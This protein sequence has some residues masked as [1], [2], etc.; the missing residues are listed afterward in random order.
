MVGQEQVHRHLDA[1]LKNFQPTDGG[2]A[3]F[4]ALTSTWGGGKTRTGDELV[5]QVTGESAGWID[6]AG[7]TLPSLMKPDFGDGLV[8]IMVSY[9][10][11]IRQVEDADRRLPFT[12]WIPR[13]TLAALLCLRDHGTP[14]SRAVMEH[15]DSFKPV[16]ARAI[17]DL[18]KLKDLTNEKSVVD[19]ILKVLNEQGLNRVLVIVEEVEDPSEIRNKPQ[20]RVLGD[21]QYQEIKDVYLDVIPEV[22][23][24]DIE[25]QRFPSLGFLLL[26]SPA[27]YSTIEKIPSQARRYYPVPIGRN[28]VADLCG[29]L[30]F[31]RNT[32]ST[33][34]EYGERLIRAAYLAVDRNMGW[35]NVVMHSVHRRFIE[36]DQDPVSLL[37]Q[38]SVT[39]PRGKEV[40]VENGLAR[41]PGSETNS[42]AQSLLFGQTPVLIES[43]DATIRTSLQQMHVLDAAG[44]CAFT[45]LCPLRA[46]LSELLQT[47]QHEAGVQVVSGGGAQVHAG[48]MRVD[49][50]RLLEDLTAYERDDAGRPVLP[51]NREQ[52]VLHVT[53][54][55]GISQTGA[56]ALYLYPVFQ[57]HL[58]EAP[59]HFGP[60]FAALR[61]IDR[62]LQREDIQFRL[63]DDEDTERK[64]NENQ[65]G[66]SAKDRLR[67]LAQGFLNTIDEP[68]PVQEHSSDEAV[69]V[70]A[71][72][73]ER[74]DSLLLAQDSKVWVVVGS[75]GTNVRDI[76][77]SLSATGQPVRPVLLLLSTDDPSQREIVDQFLANRPAIKD[78]VFLFPLAEIDERLLFLKS[79]NYG[80]NSLTNLSRSLLYRLTE[81][82]KEFLSTRF[83]ELVEDG[84]VARPLFR[85]NNWKPYAEE[86]AE[87]WLF[88]AS[89]SAHDLTQARTLLGEQFVANALE[90]L[91]SNK[92]TNKKSTTELVDH[93]SE[94]P[95]PLWSPALARI[96][97]LLKD[98]PRSI[99]FLTSRF[100][101]SGSKPREVVDQLLLWLKSLGLVKHSTQDDT[102][103][104]LK[105]GDIENAAQTAQS[106][107]DNDLKQLLIDVGR[108][109]GIQQKLNADGA[110]MKARLQLL[111]KPDRLDQ[112]QLLGQELSESGDDDLDVARRQTAFSALAVYL[113]FQ[114]RQMATDQPAKG[115]ALAQRAD[116]LEEHLRTRDIPFRDRADGLG[117]FVKRIEKQVDQLH[118]QISAAKGQYLQRLT[119]AHLPSAVFEIPAE[120]LL[121][122]T[123]RDQ[124][125]GQTTKGVM[126][127]ETLIHHLIQGHLRSAERC[128]EEAERRLALL[129]AECDQLIHQ[130]TQFVGEVSELKNECDRYNGECQDLT[131]K[132]SDP[133]F[134]KNHLH[135]LLQQLTPLLNGANDSLTGLQDMVSGD[136]SE[137][138]RSR[139]QGGPPFDQSGEPIL[140]KQAR[141]LIRD[142]HVGAEVSTVRL[143][144]RLEPL[145]NQ[146]SVY[147]SELMAEQGTPSDPGLGLLR[148]AMNRIDANSSLHA[149]QRLE[150]ATTLR[151]LVEEAYRL[152]EEWR[153]AGPLKLGDDDLF[154]FFLKVISD[155]ELGTKGIPPSTDWEK[156]GKLKDQN[157]VTLK[158]KD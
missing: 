98:G 77:Q 82:I 79:E 5:A 50:A 155:T 18:P 124:P 143:R 40:F 108:Y 13:V 137:V 145:A 141:N 72:T 92:P 47:A 100:F 4:C 96:V 60:S 78:R 144:E 69:V 14:Q 6:R 89:D 102:Y 58:A 123:K 105:R 8:P 7:T 150:A 149:Q 66:L 138:I 43:L 70:L 157:L 46:G 88:L 39:D 11:V 16:A 97:E 115:A 51:R 52:F 53:T 63:L 135:H 151:A 17:R 45:E 20:G 91:S 110:E 75:R 85:A 140:L 83:D 153:T 2:S 34:P 113:D 130:W 142:L 84:V 19:G 106:W 27:V 62:R 44:T 129:K 139:D 116:G 119:E 3:W 126:Q 148:F 132:S 136:Y 94:P 12:E 154:M 146:R 56:A 133:V 125:L 86:L 10:W 67:R 24:S 1:A 101:G 35:M 28:T 65:A 118:T 30:A 37:R 111:T 128:V 33:I 87:T 9:K 42:T 117:A 36:G 26:C 68:Q 127:N 48:D 120:G 32:D 29:Y 122:L 38:F 112:F 80:D 57:P 74:T 90:A 49:L 41:I 64:L 54:L 107:Y 95:R 121:I 109:T 103:R 71:A 59:T 81:R 61:E 134:V 21:E 23:K 156:L 99:D 131:A 15:L 158:L 31:L 104:L 76:L 22:M 25:R 147:A 73:L 114:H 152:R 55:H 93:D